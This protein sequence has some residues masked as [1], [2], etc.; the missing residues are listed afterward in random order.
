MFKIGQK[1]VY[2]NSLDDDLLYV[3]GTSIINQ[4]VHLDNLTFG[5]TYEALDDSDINWYGKQGYVC[6]LNNN[7][8]EV[9]ISENKFVTLKDYRKQK[10]IK[11]KKI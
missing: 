10:L 3:F 9:L 1:I 4:Y 5:K 2:I 6:V 7:N 8:H 11:L